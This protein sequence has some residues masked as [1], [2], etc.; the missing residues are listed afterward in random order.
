MI[1]R[2]AEQK[3]APDIAQHNMMLAA[4]TEGWHPCFEDALKGT[5][6]L[7]DH[8]EKGFYLVAEHD[9]ELVGQIMVT[10]EWSDWRNKEIWWIH[11]IFVNQEWRHQGVFSQLLEE[12]KTM[13]KQ[14]NVFVLRLYVITSNQK[15]ISLYQYLGWD[16]APFYI[17]QHYLAD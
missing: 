6:E 10:V 3:D 17:F 15:A 12:L 9:S 5:K 14:A 11:R 4:E 8:R 7:L 1:I 2:V 16:K 13:A